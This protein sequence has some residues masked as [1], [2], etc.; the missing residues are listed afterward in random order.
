MRSKK[1]ELAVVGKRPRVLT[2]KDVE[3]AVELA[4]AAAKKRGEI[5]VAFVDEKRIRELN[6]IYRR[7]DKPTD[8]L[9]FAYQESTRGPVNGDV[10][11]CQDYAKRD[12]QTQGVPF[13]EQLKRLIIH[14]TLHVCGFD[15]IKTADAKRM[16]PL[17]E[18]IL[19]RL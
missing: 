8:V 13:A 11:V 7:K 10:I 19:G 5:N 16:L 2:Q 18:R 4:L 12:S 3:R 14:G 9:S 6:R 1:I 15:H 17:Q